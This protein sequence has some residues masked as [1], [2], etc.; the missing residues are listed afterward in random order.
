MWAGSFPGPWGHW[1][2]SRLSR[3]AAACVCRHLYKVNI[4]ADAD[5][6]ERV[7]PHT[8]PAQA[9]CTWLTGAQTLGAEVSVEHRG[10]RRQRLGSGEMQLVEEAK[11]FPHPPN[12]PFPGNP[13]LLTPRGDKALAG[14]DLSLFGL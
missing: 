7:Q 3:S 2:C 5:C 9:S 4:K 14:E 1:I 13:G 10:L 12:R 11:T 8:H 6:A